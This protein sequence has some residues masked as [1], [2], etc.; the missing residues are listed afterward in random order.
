MTGSG[1]VV[2][3]KDVIDTPIVVTDKSILINPYHLVTAL[4]DHLEAYKNE[5]QNADNTSLRENF[6]RRFD[7]DCS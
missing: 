2:V 7:Y 6:E 5:L 3:S 1:I 4:K